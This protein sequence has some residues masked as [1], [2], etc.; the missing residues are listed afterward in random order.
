MTDSLGERNLDTLIRHM[1]PVLNP[2]S[3]VF[4]SFPDGTLPP[5]SSPVGLFSE[6]EGLSVILPAEQAG[7]LNLPIEPAY[8]W[9]TLSI[10][11]SLEAVGLTAAVSTALAKAGISCNMIAAFCH[12][13]IFVPVKDSGKALFILK[14]LSQKGNDDDKIPSNIL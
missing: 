9:I 2:G 4:C 10:H 8:A 1:Q 7:L 12:D 3:Y 6:I 14:N 13:H 11:S 5:G